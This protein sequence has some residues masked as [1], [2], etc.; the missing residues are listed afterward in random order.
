MSTFLLHALTIFLV[1]F[2]V[3]G[4]SV[5]IVF[6]SELKLAF[7]DYSAQKELKRQKAKLM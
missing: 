6:R 1:S 5:G 7:K 2:V 4:L 3:V